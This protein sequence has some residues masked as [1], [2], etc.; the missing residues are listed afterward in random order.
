[1][2]TWISLGWSWRAPLRW[3][4]GFF[5]AHRVWKPGKRRRGSGGESGLALSHWVLL[6]VLL[7]IRTT[8]PAPPA[9]KAPAIRGS[10]GRNGSNLALVPPEVSFRWRCC[11]PLLNRETSALGTD[12][13]NRRDL[14]LLL[15]VYAG[16][17]I[18]HVNV[19][20]AGDNGL[21]ATADGEPQM[22]RQRNTPTIPARW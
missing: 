16:A 19:T 10:F 8:I 22:E 14:L 7:C 2:L 4:F 13:V 11:S 9:N 5:F 3:R 6:P 12:E 20:V 17:H 18:D 21:T 1:M 15:P